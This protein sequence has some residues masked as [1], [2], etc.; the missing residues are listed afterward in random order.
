M[1]NFSHKD[2]PM[3]PAQRPMTL[4]PL[5]YASCLMI[6]LAIA[7]ALSQ[8]TVGDVVVTDSRP[9][10][11]NNLSIAP[12]TVLT[13]DDLRT[14]PYNNVVDM[15]RSIS[16]VMTDTRGPNGVQSDISLRGSTF[17][18]VLI[19]VDGVR[20]S[21]PQTGHHTSVIPVSI[22]EIERIEVITG[23]MAH[24]YG[25]N[26]IGGV[27]SITTK[28]QN[29]PT[30]S[31]HLRG[32]A[33]SLVDA[34]VSACHAPG[35]F[36]QKITVDRRSS[37]GY[38]A[39]TD[40]EQ[41]VARYANGF[42]TGNVSLSSS[43]AY[44]QKDFGANGFYS[45]SFPDQYE[46][47]AMIFASLSATVVLDSSQQLAV[48][49]QNRRNRDMFRLRRSDPAFYQNNHATRVTSVNAEYTAHTEQGSAKAVA[50]YGLESIESSNLGNHLRYRVSA[51]GE[52][53]WKP[54]D[55]PWTVMPA[56][57]VFKYQEYKPQLLPALSVRY[58]LDDNTDLTANAGRAFRIPTY[59][60]L[61]YKDR[62][63]RDAV[64]S[65][66]NLQPEYSWSAEIAAQQKMS[67]HSLSAAVYARQG[68]NLIDFV[69]TP[70][71]TTWMA[72][73]LS[74][75]L[76]Y[77]LEL[78]GRLHKNTLPGFLSGVD[79]ALSYTFVS[80]DQ[81]FGGLSSRYV[82]NP[83]RHKAV[84]RLCHESLPGLQH[85]WIASWEEYTSP[86]PVPRVLLD[87]RLSHSLYLWEGS[88]DIFADVSNI[89]D[90]PYNDP[91]GVPL[92]G[93]WIR[94]GADWHI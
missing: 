94:I 77:G 26:A 70:S 78:E 80:I 58:R 64:V 3:R 2:A 30:V 92:P 41:W 91:V 19:L 49:A 71:D 63:R 36:Y 88:V 5:P 57:M 22:V 28:K 21:D 69:R 65:N 62:P 67:S 35:N 13:A 4:R 34:A 55:S 84:A 74:S 59:T 32:G 1:R 29:S 24:L 47:I 56:L 48:N 44:V 7:P 43:V 86:T 38:R 61:Y 31:A 73:N 20:L 6:C 18:Q 45:P 85:S 54:K 39:N 33:H 66:P 10:A 81:D 42:N 23:A 87:A 37:T 16:K 60:E 17:E 15:L 27:I 11:H 82:L 83:V 40:Y 68:N 76:A 75:V 53:A 8:H 79:I 93:R 50:E 9:P 14:M 72:N 12:M 25:S 52:F 90:I 46:E 89:F 51:G